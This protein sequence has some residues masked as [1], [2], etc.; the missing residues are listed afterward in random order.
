MFAALEPAACFSFS[1]FS[2]GFSSCE[3][4]TKGMRTWNHLK[5]MANPTIELWPE[6]LLLCK[7]Q[8][9]T[10]QDKLHTTLIYIYDLWYVDQCFNMFQPLLSSSIYLSSSPTTVQVQAKSPHLDVHVRRATCCQQRNGVQILLSA[11]ETRHSDGVTKKRPHQSAAGTPKK[12]WVPSILM[13]LEGVLL[14]SWGDL[15]SRY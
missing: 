12:R 7:F 5:S 11:V 3:F 15:G 8:R 1:S 4:R 13:D 6:W 9:Y 10:N 14:Y 2:L